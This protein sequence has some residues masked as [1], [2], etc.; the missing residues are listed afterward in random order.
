MLLSIEVYHDGKEQSKSR[1]GKNTAL[2]FFS[3]DFDAS[4]A[5]K[6][7]RSQFVVFN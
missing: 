5:A 6:A 7:N 1:E 4:S 3:T 2:F